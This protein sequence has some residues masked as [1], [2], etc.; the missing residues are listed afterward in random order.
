MPRTLACYHVL[1]GP[2]FTL[3]ALDPQATLPEEFRPPSNTPTGYNVAAIR[4]SPPNDMV[5]EDGVNRPVLS[6]L[7]DPSNDA[8]NLDLRVWVRS[9]GDR[10]VSRWTLVGGNLRSIN[11]VIN[12]PDL[13]FRNPS[14][15]GHL[16]M[17]GLGLHERGTVRV[18]NVVMWFLRRE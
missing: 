17:F 12:N 1:T 16:V 6:F 2:G 4:F 8:R 10:E 13:V 14:S 11:V 9:T 15:T 5:L 7:L 18:S 3:P